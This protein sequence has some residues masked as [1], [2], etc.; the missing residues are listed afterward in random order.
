MVGE[1]LRHLSAWNRHSVLVAR[2]T[3]SEQRSVDLRR[4]DYQTVV[5][6]DR[7]LDWMFERREQGLLALQEICSLLSVSMA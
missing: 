5:T 3:T 2:H 1:S 4:Y 6:F 7:Y